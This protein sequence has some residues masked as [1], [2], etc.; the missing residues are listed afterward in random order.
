VGW[1][2]ENVLGVGEL[3]PIHSVCHLDLLLSLVILLFP[4]LENAD[5]LVDLLDS[6][7]DWLFVE[8]FL[9]VDFYPYFGANFIGNGL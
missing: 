7:G 3:P 6:V 4:V 5:G 1:L 8:D 9:D 2:R